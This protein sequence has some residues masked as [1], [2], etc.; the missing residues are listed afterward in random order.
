MRLTTLLLLAL[1]ISACGEDDT[2]NPGTSN[3]TLTVECDRDK[4]EPFEVGEE[5]LFSIVMETDPAV[6]IGSF[7][8]EK[9]SEELFNKSD[10]TS[11]IVNFTFGYTTIRE[12][13]DAGTFDFVFTLTDGEGRI[14]ERTITVQVAVDFPL[15][16]P[17]FNPS[18][19]WDL[20][21]DVAVEEGDAANSDIYQFDDQDDALRYWKPLN[22]S[23]LYDISDVDINSLD[24]NLKKATILAALS[25][26]EPVDSIAVASLGF[27]TVPFPAPMVVDL[28]GSGRLVVID[29]SNV[30]GSMVGYRKESE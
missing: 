19:G 17:E 5:L 29:F 12:D 8:I 6:G 28:R 16:I 11:N 10:Y 20:V 14:I 26:R 24:I 23:Q 30:Q 2:D 9:G 21:N 7:T 15:F 3:S 27:G 1:L 13:V 25:N 18:P 4:T 22:D